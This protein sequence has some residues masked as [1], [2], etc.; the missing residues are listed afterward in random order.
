MTYNQP[1][2]CRNTFEVAFEYPVHFTRGV[3]TGENPLLAETLNRFGEDRRH[4]AVVY[5]D[6]G[7]AETHPTLIPAIKRY[8]HDRP[9]AMELAGGP[10]IV[11]GGE[12]AK[13]DWSI[14]RDVMWTI[15]NLHL[16]RQSYVVAVGGGAVLDMIG[17]A[18]SIVHR[19][20]R[21]VR[22]PTTTL[23]MDDAGIGVKNGMNEH[24][25]KNFVGTFAPPH[26][27]LCDFGFLPTL[28]DEHWLGGAA[29]AFKV[30]V[31]KDADFLETLCE[32]ADDVRRRDLPA[33]ERV[34]RRCAEL[35]VEHIATHGD[36]FEF[37]SARPLD[38]GHWA[39]HRLESMTGYRLT[40]GQ[41]VS[42]GIAVDLCYAQRRGLISPTQRDRVLAAME[43]TGLP[44]FDETLTRRNPDGT[45]EV[46]G[47]IEQFRE[48]LG[49]RL[50]ITLPDGL[51]AKTEVHQMSP[52]R[53]DQAVAELKERFGP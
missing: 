38:F 46:L 51:G 4:R 16:D 10:T 7:V 1:T 35:H 37:G 25:M 26:A 28:D 17:F 50:C 29:E 11:P 12:R 45:L 34:V 32:L 52:D 39:A 15:G 3:F 20:L 30:A 19:G 18:A 36:P 43:R 23:A 44:L 42:L 24:G 22:L 5:V 48:H 6:S 33:M 8:F 9:D 49:G 2:P 40:H 53:V 13:T 14:V 47:G 31:I 27:V 21:L 41:A